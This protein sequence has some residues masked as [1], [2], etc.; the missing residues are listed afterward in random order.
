M[1]K[2]WSNI[3]LQKLADIFTAIPIIL[4]LDVM[5]IVT[6]GARGGVWE[7]LKNLRG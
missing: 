2:L 1:L 6:G 4:K 3:F 5:R 7:E